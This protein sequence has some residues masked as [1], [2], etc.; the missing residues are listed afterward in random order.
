[1]LTVSGGDPELEIWA[2]GRRKDLFESGGSAQLSTGVTVQLATI[3]AAVGV[4]A[5]VLLRREPAA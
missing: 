1:V 5:L 3:V 2:A 4:S